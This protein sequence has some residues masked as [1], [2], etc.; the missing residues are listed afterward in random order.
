MDATS[1]RRQRTMQGTAPNGLSAVYSALYVAPFG[2]STST[3]SYGVPVSTSV[4]RTFCVK[5]ES[6]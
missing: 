2:S 6:G 3:N 1:G 4:R 5:F